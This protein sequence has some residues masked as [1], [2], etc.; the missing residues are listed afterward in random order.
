M[1][2]ETAVESRSEVFWARSRVFLRVVRILQQDARSCCADWTRVFYQRFRFYE[3]GEYS[4]G[5]AKFCG[6]FW[7][8]FDWF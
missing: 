5:V 4:V 1:V 2:Q 7:C 6:G 8:Y 3:R